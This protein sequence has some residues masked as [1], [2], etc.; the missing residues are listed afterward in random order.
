M[1]LLK[2]IILLIII[3]SQHYALHAMGEG[4]KTGWRGAK[5]CYDPKKV[6]QAIRPD[7]KKLRLE[8]YPVV[9][10]K[11]GSLGYFTAPSS[12]A[13]KAGTREKASIQLEKLLRTESTEPSDEESKISSEEKK[14]QDDLKELNR[15]LL[16]YKQRIEQLKNMYGREL[17]KQSIDKNLT[18][19][20][21]DLDFYE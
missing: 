6:W 14:N 19:K 18:F 21:Y 12:Q 1:K 8:L 15:L 9:R 16:K 11:S 5:K 20:G 2:A 3:M 7:P 13:F 10:S 4:L 17:K